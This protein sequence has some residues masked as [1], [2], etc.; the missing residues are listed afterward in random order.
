MLTSVELRSGDQVVG[1]EASGKKEYEGSA[2]RWLPH[3]EYPTAELWGTRFMEGRACG[4]GRNGVLTATI[5]RQ[6]CGAPAPASWKEEHEG[7]A[8]TEYSSQLSHSRAV[9]HPQSCGAPDRGAPG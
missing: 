1:S 5:T 9:G 3:G 6:S 2:V 4:I 8:G 7:S